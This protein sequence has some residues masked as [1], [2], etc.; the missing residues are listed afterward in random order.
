MILRPPRLETE[1]AEVAAAI[2]SAIR[3]AKAHKPSNRTELDR[4]Y[5]VT[6]TELEKA[7]A[8][9][10]TFTPPPLAEK[11]QTPPPSIDSFIASLR[12]LIADI[13][14]ATPNE[15]DADL[16]AAAVA[17]FEQALSSLDVA[18]QEAAATQDQS[19][20]PHAHHP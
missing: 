10:V 16:A 15:I 1:D 9:F 17:E 3:T 19:E 13:K 8:Y 4:V 20:A 14:A 18:Q 6:I 5:A 2:V 7:Y 11:G 12:E